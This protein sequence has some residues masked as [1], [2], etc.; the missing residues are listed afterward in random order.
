MHCGSDRALSTQSDEGFGAHAVSQR[1][2]FA[3]PQPWHK[4]SRATA[5]AI[6]AFQADRS[7]VFG[8]ALAGSDGSSCGHE[9]RAQATPR[10]FRTHARPPEPFWNAGE[11]SRRGRRS[12]GIAQL[13]CWLSHQGR[14]LQQPSIRCSLRCRL[15][16]VCT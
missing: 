6:Y 10:S 1:A 11:A 4:M 16:S 15:H 8:S 2:A 13:R 12:S 14:A 7:P 9:P 3:M 5:D